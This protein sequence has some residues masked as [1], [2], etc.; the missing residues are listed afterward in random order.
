MLGNLQRYV[1]DDKTEGDAKQTKTRDTNCHVERWFGIT[2]NAILQKK[3]KLRPASFI[4]KM[5]VDLQG[6]YKEHIINNNFSEEL[7]TANRDSRQIMQ[8]QEGWAKCDDNCRSK[9]KKSK[10]FTS[11]KITPQPKGTKKRPSPDLVQTNTE[12]DPASFSAKELG[13]KSE[14]TPQPKVTRKR[15]PHD[16]VQTTTQQWDH[17]SIPMEESRENHEVEQLWKCK[18]TEV[19]IAVIR[20][21]SQKQTFTLRHR[22]FLSLRPNELLI[23]EVMECYIGATL[24]N[25]DPNERLYQMNH[26][27]MGVILHGTRE[28]VAR[29]G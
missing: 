2:K 20:N 3:L 13:E 22:E 4:R 19:V 8:A 18:A 1:H 7:L 24:K 9:K 17:V 15:P 27:T 25:Q 11:P 26:Y 16:V 5:H 6:R 10:Y 14:L 23:G 12:L 28:E 29:Q 21:T